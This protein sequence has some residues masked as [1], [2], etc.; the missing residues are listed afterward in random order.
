MPENEKLLVSVREAARMLS[1][2]DKTLWN[3]TSPRGPIKVVRIGK[4]TLYPIAELQRL[5]QEQQSA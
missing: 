4:R 5:I 1:V 3:H 2:S